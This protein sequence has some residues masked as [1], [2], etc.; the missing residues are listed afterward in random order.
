EHGVSLF[1]FAHAF[2]RADVVELLRDAGVDEPL[3]E[4][5]L[6][7]SA[8]ARGDEPTA[9]AMLSSAPDLIS[10]LSA[11]Q[12]QTMPELAGMGNIAAVRTMLALGWPREVKTAWDATALNLAVF[13]GDAQ[14]AELLL[15]NGADWRTRHGYNENVIGTLSFASV[16]EPM[17]QPAPHDYEGCARTLLA[18]GVPAPDAIYGFSDEVTAIFDAARVA[19]GVA[20]E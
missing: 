7:L 4:M 10:R 5:E 14:M 3:D 8:C 20:A 19:R 16:E 1:R 15:N 12:L 18:H 13:R 17:E 6:F 2:G 11:R 9:R